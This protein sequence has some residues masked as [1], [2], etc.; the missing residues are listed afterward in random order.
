MR[1]FGTIIF[2]LWVW[3]VSVHV[4]YLQ[5]QDEHPWLGIA[6]AS[7]F[8]QRLLDYRD[9]HGWADL[10]MSVF[11]DAKYAYE[12]RIPVAE[13]LLYTFL[14]LDLMYE[15][16]SEYVPDWIDRMGQANRLHANMP[17]RIPYNNQSLGDRLND[18]FLKYFFS[19]GDLMRKA[20]NQWDPSDLLTEVFSVLDRLYSKNRYLFTQYPDLAFA[21]AFVHDVP[22]S[23]LWPHPQVGQDVLPR[24]LRSADDVF[25]FF[26]NARNTKWFHNS[27]KRLSL[28]DAIFL[29][30]LIISPAEVEWVQK[31]ITVKPDMYDEVYTMIGYDYRRIQ[32]GQYHW[33]YDDYSLPA[34]RRVGGIC[35]DQA[36]FAS[37][38]GKAQGLPTIEFLGSGLD[39]RHAWFG[40]LPPRG[41]WQMEAGRFADQRFITGHAFNPQT[42]SF[43]SDH[44]VAF[45]GAGYHRNRAYL[46]SQIHFYWARLYSHLGE[47]NSAEKAA[48]NAVAMERRND[49]AWSLLIDL[50]KRLNLPRSRIDGSYRS[51]LSALRTYSDLEAKFLTEFADYLDATGRENSARMERSRITWKNKDSR[52]DLAIQNAAELL[53]ESI[54]EDSNAAQLYVFK[55]ILYQVGAQGGIQVLDQL[56]VPFLN[57]L[58]DKG[59]RGDARTVVLEAEKVLQP[60]AGSQMARDLQKLKNQVG[61]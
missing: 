9:E 26:T 22:P 56:V 7:V 12:R 53:K 32:S 3:E 25:S 33:M 2:F 5:G 60:T 4:S 17:A 8:P 45:L 19:R 35:V 52:S 41:K 28:S 27:I 14:W 15:N 16:E 38:V 49:A 44:E 42:W 10:R 51:A 59:R 29:V 46:S 23:P 40:Y 55:R 13:R 57:H 31:N 48:E 21:I 36:Y 6:N 58:V 54:R 30:D 20:Y 39:G 61:A 1:K 34:I 47:L 24:Q 11:E 50:R 18:K 37:Q 43:I